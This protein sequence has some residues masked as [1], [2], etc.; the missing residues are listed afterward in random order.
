MKW[1]GQLSRQG[2]DVLIRN[3]SPVH[4]LKVDVVSPYSTKSCFDTQALF[5]PGSIVAVSGGLLGLPK[6]GYRI[7]IAVDRMVS[8]NNFGCYIYG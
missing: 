3:P 6:K 7:G 8:S 5:D 2:F 4:S 1:S